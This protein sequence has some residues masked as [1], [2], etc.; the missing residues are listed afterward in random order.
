MPRSLYVPLLALCGAAASL[1]AQ[2]APRTDTPRGGTFR[3]TF[4][5]VIE[6]WDER[7]RAGR[8]EPLGAPLSGDSVGGAF[9]P[10]VARLEQDVRAAG[11][12]PGFIASLGRG[13][14]ALRAERRTTPLGIEWGLTDRVALNAV[15]PLVRV[16]T[17]ARFTLDPATANLGLNP[18]IGDAATAGPAYQ[19]FFADFDQALTQLGANLA[20]GAYG[21]PGSTQY[22]QAAAFLAEADGVRLALYRSTYGPGTAGAAPFLPLVG[23]DGGAAID[24]NILRIQQELATSYG[25]GGFTTSFL[26]PDA[27][28]D[29][30]RFDLAL[31]D[32]QYGFGVAPLI[33]TPRQLRLWPGDAEVGMRIRLVNRPA[34]AATLGALVR[35]P[36]G[37]LDSPRNPVD[38]ATGD[39]QTD[40]EGHLIQE[41]TLA[42]RLWLNVHVR[43]GTQRSVERE[44]RVA[45]PAAFLVAPGAIALTRWDPGDYFAA[46]VAP[47][48]RF[49]PSFAAGITLAYLRRGRDRSTYATAQDSLNVAAG[50]GAPVA[51]AALD[52]GTDVRVMRA[53]VALTYVGPGI[54]GG[55]SLERTVSAAG[56]LTA[57]VTRLRFVL[58]TSRWPF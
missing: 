1:A 12:L 47:L 13:I 10:A 20:G 29:A 3:V 23:S 42:G 56:G 31:A 51:A 14:L 11:A 16:H 44:R 7:F 8:R 28:L 54:E 49:S 24:A 38:L 55:L 5:P 17:R 19:T 27:T 57:A 46:D 6:V 4:A 39:G 50:L 9:V 53:G 41:L 35:L 22:Q 43:A 40:I 26:L 33:N 37:H 15:L 30:A 25:V 2:A 58:R 36:T 48:Y 52:A 21:P 18:L 32:A 45:D 34:Y